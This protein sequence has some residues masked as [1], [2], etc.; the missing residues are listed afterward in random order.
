MSEPQDSST[1]GNVKSMGSKPQ[2]LRFK[3]QLCQVL[4]YLGSHGLHFFT[5]KYNAKN[6]VNFLSDCEGPK[7]ARC[8]V[9]SLRE[10]LNKQ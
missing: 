5:M 7:D 9:Y 1:W 8:K 6:T 3:A 4:W 10:M 2:R